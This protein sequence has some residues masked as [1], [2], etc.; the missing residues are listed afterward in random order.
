MMFREAPSSSSRAPP[1][2]P[3]PLVEPPLREAQAV[4]SCCNSDGNGGRAASWVATAAAIVRVR[5]PS[6]CEDGLGQRRVL[7]CACAL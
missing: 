6:Q 3:P 2:P 4:E 1:L 5:A 7:I